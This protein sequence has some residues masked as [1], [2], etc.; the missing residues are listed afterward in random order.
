MALGLGIGTGI[1]TEGTGTLGTEPG[2]GTGGTG[3]ILPVPGT[4][5][6]LP[7]PGTGGIYL[8]QGVH[9]LGQKVLKMMIV[10][11]FER[12]D[13]YLLP[14]LHHLN[15]IVVMRD[16]EMLYQMGDYLV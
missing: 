7:V 2:T 9:F 5:G 15:Y 12:F 4:G 13:L 11:G 6:I 16:I 3:G 8:E 14:D 1:G 10:E